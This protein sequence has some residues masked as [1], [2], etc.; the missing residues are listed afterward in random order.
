MPEKTVQ[1]EPDKKPVPS[2][3]PKPQQEVVIQIPLSELH[4]FPDHPFQVREDA[5]MQ[6]TAESVKEYGVLV[7][8]L[9]R[10]REDGGYELIAGHRR[11]HA[12]EL[13]GLTTMPVIVRDIDRDAATIIMVDSNLQRENILPSER[14]QAYKMK[15]EAIR[16]KAG[17]PAKIKEKADE[18]NSPQVAANFR[19]DDTVAKDAGI[20]G[21]TVRRYIRLT[22]LSPE[23]QQMVDEKKIGMTPAVEISYL[24]PEEQQMLLTAID[25]EQ[26]TPSLSQA[27]RMKMLSRE[28]KL[29]DD[30]MLDIMME[31]KKPEKND[32]TLSGEKLRKYFP[33]SYTPFQIENTIFKLLDAW[34]KKRQRDQS[35]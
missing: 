27:Q 6:E 7:P 13:A 23:L 8:A 28:G 26:A 24:K 5:S 21:D 4:P 30:S 20:S 19:A 10:P 33:R 32:I 35:R 16:R 29:N 17:R 9:A 15:L 22:E 14:A 11:K 18:N 25:S 3:K 2:K 31:Q 12:C 34:Q 1:R